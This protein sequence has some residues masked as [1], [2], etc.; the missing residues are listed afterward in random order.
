MSRLVFSIAAVF[1]VLGLLLLWGTTS[2]GWPP[3]LLK[4]WPLGI[5]IG[6][7]I[8]AWSSNRI[9][10]KQVKALAILSASICAGVA[11][12]FLFNYLGGRL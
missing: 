2:S 8:V 9:G 3:I 4:A 7:V 12:V 1:G 11:V 6:M 5:G 10:P